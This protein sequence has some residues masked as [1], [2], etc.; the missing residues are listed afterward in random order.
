MVAPSGSAPRGGRP[1]SETARQAILDATNT[2]LETTTVRELTIEAIARQAGVGKTT[3]YRWWPSKTA[4]VID[5]FFDSIVPRTSF[6]PAERVSE[7]LSQQV[8]RLIE[9]YRGRYGRIVAELIAE[10]Q[11]D[12][13]VLADFRERYLLRRRTAARDLIEQ[14]KSTGELH[15]DLDSD[16]MCDLIYGSIYYRLLV[17]HLPLDEAFAEALPKQ[18]LAALQRA[19]SYSSPPDSPSL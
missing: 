13:D 5:A 19:G 10:G 3:I 1:R 16:L 14:G 17:G 9:Q 12:P 2:L 4:V 8:A 18:V 6:P 11:A 15:P 7:A